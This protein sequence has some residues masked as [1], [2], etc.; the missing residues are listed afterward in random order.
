MI[1]VGSSAVIFILLVVK[2]EHFYHRLLSRYMYL[3]ILILLI[4]I[5]YSYLIL[6]KV[7]YLLT[8]A[9]TSWLSTYHIMAHLIH[10]LKPLK[11]LSMHKLSFLFWETGCHMLAQLMY[12]S[13]L[14]KLFERIKS[15]ITW[16]FV[17]HTWN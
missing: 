2:F 6:A 3:F 8:V 9:C 16:T 17:V 11:L 5:F 1:G 15:Q 7:F 14:F 10:K 13:G 12:R 4:H